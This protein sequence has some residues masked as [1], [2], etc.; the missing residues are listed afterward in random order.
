[1]LKSAAY[2]KTHR[3]AVHRHEQR[4][5]YLKLRSIP[6]ITDLLEKHSADSPIRPGQLSNLKFGLGTEEQIQPDSAPRRWRKRNGRQSAN[7][8][9]R[10]K[11]PGGLPSLCAIPPRQMPE[12]A[13]RGRRCYPGGKFPTT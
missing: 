13:R 10:R 4:N 6:R 3:E 8:G 2:R 12:K 11:R 5:P 7:A 9:G 1:V